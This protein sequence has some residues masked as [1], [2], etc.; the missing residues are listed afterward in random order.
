MEKIDREGHVEENRENSITL[1]IENYD[2]ENSAN[3]GKHSVLG[4]LFFFYN[5]TY[6]L[7]I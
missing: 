6:F 3:I 1:N 2:D 5:L 7:I 4:F